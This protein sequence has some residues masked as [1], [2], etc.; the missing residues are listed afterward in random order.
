VPEA[1]EPKLG[2]GKLPDNALLF[3]NLEGSPLR[4]SAIRR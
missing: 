1:F 3:A 4:P 2:A